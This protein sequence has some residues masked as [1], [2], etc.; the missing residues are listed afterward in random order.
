MNIFGIGFP[1]LLFIFVI[2]LIVLG[3]RNMVKTSRQL[4]T[5]IRKFVTSDTWKSIIHSTKEI[6]DIQGQII[7]D[8]GLQESINTL[9]NSTRDLVNPSI[10]KWSPGPDNL[11][12]PPDKQPTNLSTDNKVTLPD[13]NVTDSST[14]DNKSNS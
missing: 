11:I 2:A 4:S 3:P 6:R 8:T 9:R 1:E 13:S 10:A 14:P 5:A 12:P 7:E